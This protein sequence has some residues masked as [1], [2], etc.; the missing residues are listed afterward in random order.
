[1][2]L[3]C[4]QQLPAHDSI[5]TSSQ[6]VPDLETSK[7]LGW[8]FFFMP[9]ETEPRRVR[10]TVDVYLPGECSLVTHEIGAEPRIL[11]RMMTEH[12]NASFLPAMTKG[13]HPV[14]VCVPAEQRGGGI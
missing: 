2:G 4:R 3:H 10:L 11:A 9:P 1:M 12:L 7:R 5:N 6:R 13:A 8:Q 14:C